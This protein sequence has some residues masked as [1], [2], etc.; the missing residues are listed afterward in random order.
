MF[1]DV[2][3]VYL[4]EL[5]ATTKCYFNLTMIALDYFHFE[6]IISLGPLFNKKNQQLVEFKVLKVSKRMKSLIDDRD[7]PSWPWLITTLE[8]SSLKSL[9]LYNDFQMVYFYY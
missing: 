6:V 9:L 8:N 3:S 4:N 5:S 2:Q 1:S 7:K